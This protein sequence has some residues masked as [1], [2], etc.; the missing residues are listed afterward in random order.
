[1]WYLEEAV[2]RVKHSNTQMNSPNNNNSQSEQHHHQAV[3]QTVAKFLAD[4]SREQMKRAV[5]G[6]GEQ[7]SNKDHRL[8]YSN[9]EY[10]K[11]PKSY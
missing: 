9:D 11:K 1:M 2:Y 5:Q 7:I 8:G 10:H 6:I 4:D 3:S